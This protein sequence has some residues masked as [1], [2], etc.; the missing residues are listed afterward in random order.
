[1]SQNPHSFSEHSGYNPIPMAHP[2][3]NPIPIAQAVGAE[4]PQSAQ[5]AHAQAAY[6]QHIANMAQNYGDPEDAAF[7]MRWG[8]L[9]ADCWWCLLITFVFIFVLTILFV[10]AGVASTAD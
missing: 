6:H 9:K 2:V 7:K 8:Y 5:Q 1:M 10:I 4:N 3:Y